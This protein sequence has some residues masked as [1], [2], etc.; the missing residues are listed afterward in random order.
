MKL[1]QMLFRILALLFLPLMAT[2]QYQ[3]DYQP[4]DAGEIKLELE[5]ANKVGTVLYL[6]AHPDDENTEVMAYLANEAKVRTAYLSLTRGD[7]GQNLIGSEKGKALGVLRTR[8]LLGARSVDQGLQFFSRANDFGYSKTAD[9][10]LE[11]WDQERVLSDI[12]W[13]IRKLQPDVIITRF[14]S[15]GYGGHGHH[16]ASGM[17]AEQAYKAAS[18]PEK[19]PQQL[20]YID[21]WEPERLMF[22]TSYWFYRGKEGDMDS[23][24]FLHT[25]VG[26]YNALL[27]LSYDELGALSSS[28][29]KSQG[30]GD[31]P[32]RGNQL[33]FF[34][35]TM[36]NKAKKSI[37]EGI[38]TNWDR[39]DGGKKVGRHL[40][41]ALNEYDPDNPSAIT[42][43]LV[44]AYKALQNLDNDHWKSYKSDKI[45]KLIL[46][47]NGC[48]MDATTEKYYGVPG[49]EV[50]V[51]T[52]FLKR[53]DYPMEVK[54][55]QYPFDEQKVIVETSIPYNSQFEQSHKITIPEATPY[56]HPYWLR[57][58][59]LGN[60][61]Y[62]V[63]NQKIIGLPQTPTPM[64]VTFQIKV[65]DISF[66][67]TKEI[68]HRWEDRVK[69]EKYRPFEIG[70]PATLELP[71]KS[72]VFPDQSSKTVAVEVRCG[73]DSIF[74]KV[75]LE[76]PDG[77]NCSPEF[78]S[79][80]INGKGKIKKF[81]FEVTPPAKSS[82]GQLQA[83]FKNDKGRYKRGITTINYDHIEHQT[84]FPVSNMKVA[85]LDIETKGKK[86]GY[87]MGT[88]DEVP[89]ALRQLGYEVTMIN[90]QNFDE[91]HLQSLDAV[92]LGVRTY[93]TQNWITNYQKQLMQ[94]VED[95]GTMLVQYNKNR[96]LVTKDIG[97]Y[98]FKIEYKR[99]TDEEAP[100]KF[101]NPDHPVLNKPNQITKAD[102]EEWVQERGLYFPGEWDGNYTPIL[103]SNDP[104]ED[105]L[106]GSLLVTDY[107]KGKYIYT[108]LAFFRQLPAGVPGAYRLFANLIAYE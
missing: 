95:G 103:S 23:S 42:P 2:S 30:F 57:K 60:G 56:T 65:D 96:N 4:L 55:I 77:W 37:L 20:R 80:N 82:E 108:G 18:N 102:F 62:R 32:S 75:G 54:A 93:N 90:E 17:L 44:K 64:E 97:P 79:V 45:K 86:I 67:V 24:K 105:P 1:N 26:Q 106:K 31:A 13:I 16:T 38:N 89:S 66:K 59:M 25:N 94:Y 6:A 49:S 69:G 91:V 58:P 51:N 27:G 46:A 19:F 76:V 85:R 99:V 98:P 71:T 34:D 61:M 28:H 41:Q 40:N 29:H 10:T 5:K 35:H 74:G 39:L 48:W 33:E 21:T 68:R 3:R 12:V 9:E 87:I 70:P 50:T 101:L 14:P 81:A 22:N 52:S 107:G 63:N 100:M 11:I 47:A 92:L 78:K 53:N 83:Y 73:K 8:E 43:H 88:G 84:M 104:G 15:D 36:G 72:T 7:G